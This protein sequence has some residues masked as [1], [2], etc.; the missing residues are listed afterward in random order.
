MCKKWIENQ[1][2]SL[3]RIR[4]KILLSHN[5]P[6]LIAAFAKKVGFQE[7]SIFIFVL[8]YPTETLIM[9]DCLTA[10]ARNTTEKVTSGY[11]SAT[12]T[13]LCLFFKPPFFF[14]LFANQILKQVLLIVSVHGGSLNPLYRFNSALFLSQKVR[15]LSFEGTDS[16]FIISVGNLILPLR[17]LGDCMSNFIQLHAGVLKLIICFLHIVGKDLVPL[18]PGTLHILCSACLWVGA[19]LLGPEH[20][21]K[22][23]LYL[24]VI[25][26]FLPH[27]SVVLFVWTVRCLK[28]GTFFII[29]HSVRKKAHVV[30][31]LWFLGQEIFISW[32]Q[33]PT[34][35]NIFFFI[36]AG[37]TDYKPIVNIC[38]RIITM[39]YLL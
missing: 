37:F 31:L 16:F 29:G 25:K 27:Q 34:S 24:C 26:S 10:R 32:I 28:Y 38:I 11:L 15:I 36:C 8:E 1:Q 30:L 18:R 5:Q 13:V 12:F 17:S 3:N 23:L 6:F 19:V 2:V 21:V 39:E 9:M 35:P 7:L 14:I 4:K 33:V 20:R 22:H